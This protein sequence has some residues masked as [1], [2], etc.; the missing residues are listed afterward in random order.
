[1]TVIT[2]HDR[3]I[4]FLFSFL[5]SFEVA[6]DNMIVPVQQMHLVCPVLLSHLTDLTYNGIT[7]TG[8]LCTN[9]RT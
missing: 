7:P 6:Y 8:L 1:M 3:Y 5:A 2:I 4:Q 9:V